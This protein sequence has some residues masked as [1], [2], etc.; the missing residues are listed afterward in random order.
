MIVS[1]IELEITMNIT[2]HSRIFK[3][4]IQTISPHFSDQVRFSNPE[5]IL[6]SDLFDIKIGSGFTI[7]CFFV[8]LNG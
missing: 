3:E 6:F 1:E 5:Y 8:G 2:A 7:E 4:N